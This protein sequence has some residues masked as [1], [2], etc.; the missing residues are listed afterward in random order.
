MKPKLIAILT[1]FCLLSLLTI[2]CSKT[3][4]NASDASITEK[5]SEESIDTTSPPDENTAVEGEA[6]VESQ[7]PEG[8]GE[9]PK[10]TFAMEDLNTDGLTIEQVSLLQEVV[11]GTKTIIDLM[12][13]ELFTSE[14]LESIGV[15]IMETPDAGGKG[16]PGNQPSEAPAGDAPTDEPP[17]D[18]LPALDSTTVQ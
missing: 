9:M 5:S 12:H 6:P 17:T 1:I 15:P 2:G 7:S 10:I 11:E 14:Q 4:S 13:S 3:S 18:E 16:G 8:R